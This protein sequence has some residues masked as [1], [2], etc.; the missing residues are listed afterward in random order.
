MWCVWHMWRAWCAWCVVLWCVRGVG[1]LRGVCDLRLSRLL[2]LSHRHPS[3]WPRDPTEVGGS[4]SSEL[5]VDDPRGDCSGEMMRI[6][7]E[8]C[9]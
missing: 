6:V 9:V 8:I 5:R 1:N 4:E 2:R 3:H 7:G